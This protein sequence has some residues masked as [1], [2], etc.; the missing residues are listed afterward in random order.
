MVEIKEIT[1]KKDLKDF[2]CFPDKLYKGNKY[3]VPEL[4]NDELDMLIPETNFAFEYSD[5]KF[6][7]AL[8]DGKVVG[9]I[10]AIVNRRSNELWDQKQI[11]ITRMDFI[12]DLEV[13]GA[14]FGA[15]EGWAKQLGLNEAH[16]PLGFTDLDKERAFGG[17]VRPHGLVGHNI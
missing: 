5:A 11:R 15:V 7:L 17:G 12:D 9:R 16:G 4:K 14:L 1:S 3:Y 2:I 13:S 8:S 6:F 10:G